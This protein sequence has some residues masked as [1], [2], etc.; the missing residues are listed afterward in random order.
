MIIPPVRIDTSPFVFVA[1]RFLGPL[2]ALADTLIVKSICVEL[3]RETPLIVMSP[4][5][6]AEMTV[7]DEKLPPTMK[8]CVLLPLDNVTGCAYAAPPLAAPTA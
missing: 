1:I 6:D 7:F 8:T 4:G 3:N 5:P 2:N